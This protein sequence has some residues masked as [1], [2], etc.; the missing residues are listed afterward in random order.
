MLNVKYLVMRSQRPGDLK[1]I[2]TQ[3]N[4]D[5][6]PRA[7]F[8]DTVITAASRAAVFQT[9]RDRS[10]N[11]RTTAI[12]ERPLPSPVSAAPDTS[13]R[14]TKYSSRTITLA[15]N[16]TAPKLLVLSE[17]YYPAGWSA[18]I[19]GKEAEI[20]KTNYVLRSVIVPAGAR[21]VEFQFHPASYETGLTVTNAAWGVTA[22]LLVAGAFLD[23]RVRKRLGMS[24]G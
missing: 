20:L 14:I 11:P 1:P 18:T 21:T 9:L 17:V 19:D 6:C 10:W 12:L 16:T 13:V 2:L 22:L 7:W 4:P 24:K 5:A 23:P 15:V 3:V 8:V